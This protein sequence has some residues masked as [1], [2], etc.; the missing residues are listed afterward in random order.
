[1]VACILICELL[2]G[3]LLTRKIRRCRSG[4]GSCRRGRGTSSLGSHKQAISTDCI[5]VCVCVCVCAGVC[6]CVYENEHENGHDN[7]S[8]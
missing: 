5:G 2:D 1:M 7:D 8:E 6:V 3:K 4:R